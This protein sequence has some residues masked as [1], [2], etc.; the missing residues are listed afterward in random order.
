MRKL[1]LIIIGIAAV[2]AYAAARQNSEKGAT[3]HASGTFEIKMTPAAGGE[4]EYFPRMVSDKQFSGDLEGTSK[5][6]MLASGPPP[7]GPKGS[8]GYVAMERVT[9]SWQTRSTEPMSIPSS[10]DA[11][12][13][14][15]LRS[16][17]FRRSSAS[18]RSLA[19]RLP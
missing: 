15:A 13:T 5:G 14:S 18:R 2:C 10:S 3:M 6:E 9:P 7:S 11:V 16:P 19:E 1:S 8:G 4:S 17:R 12:A